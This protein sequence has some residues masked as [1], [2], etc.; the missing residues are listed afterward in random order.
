MNKI[1]KILKKDILTARRDSLLLYIIIAPIL[2]AFAILF[3]SPGVT[4]SAVTVALLD[5]EREEYIDY[6]ADSLQVEQFKN[7]EELE[8]RVNKKDDVIAIHPKKDSYELILQGNED[9]SIIENVKLI[10]SFYELGATKDKS[11]AK[12]YSYQKTVPPLKT[13]L[14]N[15]LI[16]M[17]IMLAGMI[18]SLGIVEEKSDQTIK[19]MNVSPISQNQFILGKSMLGGLVSIASIIISL[20]ILGYTNIN[21][22]M[23]LVMALSSMILTSLIGFLQGIA[24]KDVIEAASGVKLMFLPII[25][26]IAVYELLADK[27]QWTMY[28]NPFY[29]SYR[30]NDL[31]LSQTADWTSVIFSFI[32]VLALSFLFY[33]IAMPKIRKGLN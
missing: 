7:V 21:W 23:L 9:E 20:V 19:A 22:L 31:I 25:G 12:I 10:H 30:S 33:W 4:D 27:W 13:K 11:N 1:R 3:F 17:V 28:W 32:V 14:T 15:A 26:A 18:I 8:R 6:M 24:S 5:S 2:L 16:L 29:W